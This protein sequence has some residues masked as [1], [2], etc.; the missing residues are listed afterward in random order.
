LSAEPTAPV[1]GADPLRLTE[2]WFIRRGL[3]MF[4]ED[5]SSG[6]DVWTRA[7]PVLVGLLVLS[8]FGTVFIAR[9]GW[10]FAGAVVGTSACVVGYALWNRRAGRR[11]F[12]LPGRVTVPWLAVWV[13]V[14]S[15]LQLVVEHDLERFAAALVSGVLL[16]ALIYG[17]TR[18]A[19][20]ALTLWAVRWT[21][22]QL[23]DVG[24]L[25][26]RVLPLLLLALTFLF[27]STE[28]WQVAGTMSAPVLWATLAVFGALG[29]VFIVGRAREEFD[30]IEVETSRDAVVHAAVGTP[31]EA[32]APTLPDLERRVPMTGRQRA[33][34]LLVMVTAQSVQVAIVGVVVWGFFLIFGSLAISVAVQQSWLGSVG[35]VDVVWM[36]SDG[37]ALTRQLF[38]V[39]TFLGGFAGF[40]ATIYAAQ[41]QVYRTHFAGRISDTLERAL[42]VRRAYL[43][44]RRSHGLAA[45]EPDGAA[46]GPGL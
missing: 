5:Y 8:V 7:L 10:S 30:K 41:D 36:W 6:R 17:I 33:N 27:I 40:Y 37:R 32:V 22:Q 14:P 23:G 39:A 9:D 45:P 4:V 19:L 13:V 35:E 12:A 3:P 26:T 46:T 38:R 16:L 2:R 21:F 18:Y 31:L 28:V 25:I 42:A 29:V 43:A 44:E 34:L 11:A 1:A 24:R 20:V 15:V